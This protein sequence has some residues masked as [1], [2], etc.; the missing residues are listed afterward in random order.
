MPY[1]IRH[2]DGTIRGVC[3]NKPG[4]GNL[5]PDGTPEVHDFY[6]EKDAAKVAEVA[7]FRA[8]RD[9][10]KAPMTT[11]QKLSALGITSE[12]LKAELAK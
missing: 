7:A 8:A 9:A 1:I 11:A 4:D 3:T 2:Q 5:M 6:D 12:E 10:P